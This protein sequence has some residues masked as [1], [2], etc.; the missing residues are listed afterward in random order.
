MRLP[1][2]GRE[3]AT[4]TVRRVDAQDSFWRE[5]SVR[6]YYDTRRFTKTGLGQ[7]QH[8]W[9]VGNESRLLAPECL[10]APA[11]PGRRCPSAPELAGCATNQRTAPAE[12]TAIMIVLSAVFS[13]ESDEGSEDMKC[14]AVGSFPHHGSASNHAQRRPFA[15]AEAHTDPNRTNLPPPASTCTAIASTCTRV[16]RG[17]RSAFLLVLIALVAAAGCSSSS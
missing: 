16:A 17:A 3:T 13:L 4:C 10:A 8:T 12:E 15:I 6:S 7:A 9:K 5:L 1:T 11:P 2:I 14:C